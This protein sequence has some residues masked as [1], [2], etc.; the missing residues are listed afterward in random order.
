MFF[1][2]VESFYVFVSDSS[3]H[4]KILSTQKAMNYKLIFELQRI[5][6]TRWT[7]EVFTCMSLK[8]DP[9]LVVLVLFIFYFFIQFYLII[10]FFKKVIKELSQ[11]VYF[12]KWTLISY[13]IWLCFNMCCKQTFKEASHYLQ[14]LNAGMENVYFISSLKTIFQNMRSEHPKSN[15]SCLV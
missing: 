6:L 12:I 3:V 15:A 1:N 10:M 13:S 11:M 5:C 2:V 9:C 4:L 8:K 7:A 14:N